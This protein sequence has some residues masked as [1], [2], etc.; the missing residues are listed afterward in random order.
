MFRFIKTNKAK[1]LKCKS[2]VLSPADNPALE[3]H[4]DC[5]NLCISGGT[6]HLVRSGTAGRDYEELSII[7]I[8]SGNCPEIKEDTQPAPPWQNQK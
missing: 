4:C 3:C 1:C 5:G 2:V 7:S 8:D 6:T